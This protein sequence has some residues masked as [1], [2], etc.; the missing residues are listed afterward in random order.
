MKLGIVGLPNVG[1]STLFNAIT[2][3][4]VA[5]ENYPFCTIAPN[6]K[7]IAVPDERL[8]FLEKLYKPEKKI[9]AI[10]EFVDIAGLIKGAS[11]GE[12]LGNQFLAH[13]RDSAAIIHMVRCFESEKTAHVMDI[14]DPLRDIE[15]VNTELILADIG[16]VTKKLEKGFKSDDRKK[17]TNKKEFMLRIMTH[18]N[19]GEPARTF[20]LRD[21]EKIMLEDLF[22]ITAK[23]VLYVCNVSEND[24]PSMENSYTKIVK[25]KFKKE[26]INSICICA[27]IEAE[28]SKMSENDQKIFCKSLNLKKQSLNC[29]I[30]SGYNLLELETF[31]TVGSDEVKAWTI[32]KGC[33]APEAAGCIHSDFRRGFICA[34]VMK[35]NDLY[36]L[37]SEK[38][39]K[40]AGLL[41]NEG[42]DYLVKDGDIIKFYFNV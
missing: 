38:T 30:R 28:L 33:L 41:K 8:D 9:P 12:G 36:K 27:V 10:V 34:K 2:K 19:A 7:M 16:T 26:G 35:F 6:T 14:V 18:L 39:L 29:L 3:S 25:E 1:K 5:A 15:I 17:N 37:G 23:P 42:K 22:L 31:F 40:N 13:I 11:D 24:L 20:E 21:D 32:K 4:C